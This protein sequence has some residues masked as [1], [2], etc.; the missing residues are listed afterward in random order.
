MN[1][2][3][4]KLL[5]LYGPS[6][7]GKSTL[8]LEILKMNSDILTPIIT[9]TTRAARATEIHAK[10]YYFITYEEFL[11]K[12]SQDEFIHVTTYLNNR[13]GAS[14][15][16]I[17]D[18]KAGKNLIAIFDR[19]GAQEVNNSIPGSVLIWITAPINELEKRLRS[20]YT[21]NPE[22]FASRFAQVQKDIKI[23]AAEKISDYEVINRDLEKALKEL[24]DIIKKELSIKKC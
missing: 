21:E 6:G 10:D 8:M 22:Q 20:R 14:K 19:V 4:G 15:D 16:C 5:I 12:Q 11:L 9:Y 13:Y 23:E 2:K 17:A 3:N 1:N 7:A 18:L 24:E